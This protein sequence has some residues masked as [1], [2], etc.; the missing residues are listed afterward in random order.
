MVTITE[1]NG[2]KSSEVH[3]YISS[4]PA[5]VKAFAHSVRRHWSIENSLHWLLDMTFAEDTSHIRAGQ[6]TENFGFLRKFVISL[7]DWDTSRDSI[8]CK[9][10]EPAGA[11]MFLKTYYFSAD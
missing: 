4:L 8:R 11:P 9:K 5:I 2:K 10:N 3:N 7:L 6:G 1:G